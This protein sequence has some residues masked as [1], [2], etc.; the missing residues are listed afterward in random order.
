LDVLT[1]GH[2]V[3]ASEIA[4]LLL[5]LVEA[6]FLRTEFGNA[7]FT[8][9]KLD[10]C[11]W[12]GLK[13]NESPNP[14]QFKPG[15]IPDIDGMID[16]IRLDRIKAAGVRF[17][18]AVLL[19]C[20]GV[21]AQ[22]AGAEFLYST[23][24]RCDLTHA[25]FTGVKF[26]K[27]NVVLNSSLAHSNFKD[28]VIKESF[29][30]ETD[31]SFSDM[32]GAVLTKCYF[33]SANM[34]GSDF[35]AV[36]ASVARFERAD[37]TNSTFSSARLIGARFTAA[38]LQGAVFDGANVSFADFSQSAIDQRTSFQDVTGSYAQLPAGLV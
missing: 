32:S 19:G 38:K 14:D 37:L 4:V 15:E 11:K 12:L 26:D 5:V 2:A 13:M 21:G 36:N 16:P 17:E 34:T 31:L 28:A 3:Y 25:D 27:T 30:G 1:H 7:D 29:F 35:N 8:D 22:F 10:G 9:A 20:K 23:I 6:T 18:K 33:G 24:A